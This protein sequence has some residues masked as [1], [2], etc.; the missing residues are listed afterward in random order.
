MNM[1]AHNYP[2]EPGRRGI[3]T[4][5]EAAD[6]IAKVQGRVQRMVLFAIRDSGQRRPNR[7]AKRAIV[8]VAGMAVDVSGQAVDHG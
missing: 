8:W 1:L 6:A 7:N 2:A 4:S 3:D 5:I